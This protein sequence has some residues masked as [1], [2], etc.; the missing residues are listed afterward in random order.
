MAADDK[1]APEPITLVAID[2]GF[3]LGHM[4]EPGESFRFNP[5]N[6]DGS[7]RKLPKWAAPAGDPRLAKPKPRAA[8]DLK[9][10]DAQ[11]AVRR[12]AGQ[13]TGATDGTDASA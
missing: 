11:A 10:K 6:A 5:V 8:G 3:V 2:R 4:V 1:K 9:P 13:L 12:K 7:P